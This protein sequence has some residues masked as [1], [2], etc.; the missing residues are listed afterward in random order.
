MTEPL[1]FRRPSSFTAAE[2][3]ALIGAEAEPGTDATR[4]VNSVAPLDR[5]GPS[6]LA[7]YDNRKLAAQFRDTN[8]GICLV[9]PSLD[10]R[11]SGSVIL[12]VVKQPYRAFV[13]VARALFPEALRPSSLFDSARTP[14]G[15][16]VHPTARLENNV[17]IDPG[18]V[19][20]PGAEIGA[21]TL[22][23]A[24][25]VIGAQVR[26]GRNCAIGPGATLIHALIGDRVVIH[27]GAHI[28]QDGFGYVTSSA[29]HKKVPQIGRVIIQDDVEI[30]AGTTIDR[31]ANRDT[32]I[33][34]GSKIDNLVQ[35]AHNVTVGRQCV[36]ASL[37]GIS[38]SVV[39]GDNAMLGGQIGVADHLTIG[40]GARV[41]SQS[42]VVRDIPA[43]ETWFGSPAL[44]VREFWRQV[45]SLSQNTRRA[46]PPKSSPPDDRT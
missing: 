7:F 21:D 32:V 43:G 46:R 41:G 37:T 44:P 10:E 27:P 30:G 17:I 34:E 25:A 19:I 11:P 26:I 1:F 4:L 9:P 15:T 18:A 24:N 23:G 13:D 6:D 40:E 35:I 31:G 42:G 8:A 20:G 2:I 22:I 29:G 45:A 36:I 28:G 39:I 14:S 12:L 3:A 5:A 16:W 38:G 33:G